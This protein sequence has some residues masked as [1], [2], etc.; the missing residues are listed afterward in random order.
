MIKCIASDVDGTLL[1][2]GTKDLNPEYYQLIQECT[3]KGI[4][5]V[6]A[7]G[8][9]YISMKRTFLPVLNEAIF[10]CDNG[11]NIMYQ[12]KMLHISA[13]P[14]DVVKDV[15]EYL[16]EVADIYV[17]ISTPMEAF[18]ESEDK[19][20]IEK[21][22]KGYQINIQKVEDMTLVK[23]PIIKI[24]V[25]NKTQDASILAK[26]VREKFADRVDVVVSG[27]FWFDFVAKDTSKGSSL[28]KILKEYN[29]S[30]DECMAFGDNDNDIPMLKCA[31]HSY[32]VS[33]ARES[34]KQI[35]AHVLDPIQ[36][37]VLHKIKE[38]I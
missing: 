15:V 23:D 1:L 11:A 27:D 28:Q 21:F 8:R 14:E 20:L 33:T 35:V 38:I 13:I 34:V 18:S 29:I 24:A 6:L 25:Y 5:F 37:A 32:A 4:K 12:E 10:I 17:Q 19:A 7:S 22:E 3:Q 26:I 36:D 31:T 16:R 9:Q 30:S 2:E